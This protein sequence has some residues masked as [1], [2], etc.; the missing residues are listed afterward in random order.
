MS[1]IRE[2]QKAKLSFKLGDNFE[3]ELE[4]LVKDV[5][6]DR[7]LLKFPKEMLKYA[8]YLEEGKEVPVKIFTPMGVK[9]FSAMILDSPL[10]PDFVIEY[11]EDSIQIQRREYSRVTLETKVIIE[12]L[13]DVNIVT[14]T[15]DISGGGIRFFYEGSFSPDELINCRLYLPFQ[16]TSIQSKGH[17]INKPHLNKNEHVV[18]FNKI[19]ESDRAKI[20]KK[21][22]EVEAQRYKTI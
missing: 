10:S 20:I 12:R 21:C 3:Q 9:M 14:H 6:N 5:Q 16:M 1:E 13:E 7:L 15:I 4:C 2:D 18:L 11:V 8:K 22:F 19:I 17:I